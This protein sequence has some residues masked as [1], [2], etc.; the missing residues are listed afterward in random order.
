MTT[1]F[2]IDQGMFMADYIQVAFAKE[3]DPCRVILRKKGGEEVGAVNMKVLQYAR[4][5][6]FAMLRPATG[7]GQV[8][9]P[10]EGEYELVVNCKGSDIGKMGFSAKIE[11]SGDAFKPK[12]NWRLRGPWTKYG[13]LSYQ[14]ENENEP[15]RLWFWSSVS[16]FGGKSAD[17][18]TELSAGGKVIA[19]GNGYLTVNREPWSRYYTDLRVDK[20]HMFFMKDLNKQSG[21]LTLKLIANGKAFRTFPVSVKG[22]EVVRYPESDLGYQPR[23]NIFFAASH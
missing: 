23:E 16:E 11:K 2:Y 7:P 20:N 5:P 14:P 18:T 4:T 15:L 21:T 13:L 1:P 12:T 19:T 9:M 17:I 6:T 8:K 10:G 3:G 22:G